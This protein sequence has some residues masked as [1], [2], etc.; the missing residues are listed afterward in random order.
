MRN[1]TIGVLSKF[2]YSVL[3]GSIVFAAVSVQAAD[4]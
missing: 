1:P 3:F 4:L 2:V